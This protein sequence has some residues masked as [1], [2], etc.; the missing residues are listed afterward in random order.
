VPE[1]LELVSVCAMHRF[2]SRDWW[3]Y[4]EKKLYLPA[5]KFATVSKLQ[6][7]QALVFASRASLTTGSSVETDVFTLRVRERV[8]ADR[9]ATRKHRTV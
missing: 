6:P 4:L 2:H 5:E 9:G 3:S 7:G 1:L 8:T